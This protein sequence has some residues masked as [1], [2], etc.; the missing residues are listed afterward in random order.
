MDPLTMALLAIAGGTA[1][2]SFGP[3]GFTGQPGQFQTVQTLTPQQQE[4]QQ[5]IMSG[6]GQG[7]DFY[8]GILGGDTSQ[9]EKLSAPLMRQFEREVVPGIAGRFAAGNSMRGS[10]FQNA[11]ARAG[12]DLETNIGALQANLLSQAAGGLTG[13][14]GLGMMPSFQNIYRP[15]TPGGIDFLGQALGG[16][17]G[18]IGQGAGMAAGKSIFGA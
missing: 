16:I 8:K 10:S 3:G 11:L 14:S 17:F 9:L 12:T 13:M 6:G 15:Q 18:G 4:F 2:S 1:A 7:M 5:S